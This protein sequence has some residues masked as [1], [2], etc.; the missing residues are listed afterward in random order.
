MTVGVYDLT[1]TQNDLEKPL[2]YTL[3]DG[4]VITVIPA[5]ATVTFHLSAIG[6]YGPSVGG[7]ACTIVD[8]SNG[9]VSYTW[10]T[11]D[12]ATPGG[13]WGT[14]VITY[15]DGKHRTYPDTGP[16]TIRVLPSLA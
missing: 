7:G 9:A 8:P 15:A 1:V 4:G 5:G 6:T 11:G 10:Q 13:Y 2:T 14:F 16:K 12:L 3:T